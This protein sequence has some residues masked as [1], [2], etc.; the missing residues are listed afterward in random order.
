MFSA[1]DILKMKRQRKVKN[2]NLE[3]NVSVNVD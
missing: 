1:K 3:K 2:A